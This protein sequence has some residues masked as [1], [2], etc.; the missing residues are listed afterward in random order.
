MQMEFTV[1]ANWRN[2]C[3]ILPFNIIMFGLDSQG[4]VQGWAVTYVPQK[5]IVIWFVSEDQHWDTR[6]PVSRLR[7]FLRQAERQYRKNNSGPSQD[8]R[9][10]EPNYDSL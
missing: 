3:R 1:A 7:G 2:P 6:T 4:N 9:Q 10:H 8:V 5:P